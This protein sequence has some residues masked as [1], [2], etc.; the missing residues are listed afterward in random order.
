MT[1]GRNSSRSSSRTDE[2]SSWRRRSA[3][4]EDR[5]GVGL[6][7]EQPSTR[8]NVAVADNTRGVRTVPRRTRG[9]SGVAASA[10]GAFIA[11]SIHSLGAD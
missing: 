6:S 10:R 8:T 11:G 2:A 3:S 7:F 9:R 1:T 4:V 5:E